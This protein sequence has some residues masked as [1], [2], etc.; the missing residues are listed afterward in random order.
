VSM[1]RLMHELLRR[2]LKLLLLLLLRMESGRCGDELR[3]RLWRVRQQWLVHRR[4][5]Q[6]RLLLLLV[7][8]LMMWWRSLVLHDE[9]DR[10]WM[11]S[12]AHVNRRWRAVT[13]S[14]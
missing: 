5:L 1:R 12:T 4:V 9:R 7:M 11:E 10:G 6:Q 13:G 8:G 14:E 3:L 2:L